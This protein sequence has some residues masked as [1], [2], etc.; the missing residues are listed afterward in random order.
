MRQYHFSLRQIPGLLFV[1]FVTLPT[2]LWAQQRSQDCTQ[3]KAPRESSNATA[4]SVRSSTKPGFLGFSHDMG[5]RFDGNG[6]I[7]SRDYPTI[8][9]IYCGLPAHKAGLQVGDIVREVNDNDGRTP[10]VLR[11]ERGGIRFN[12]T[13]DRKGE[14]MRFV[15]VAVDRPERGGRK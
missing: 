12:L 10:G 11:A 5:L 15:L 6:R 7:A 9:R 4:E 13:I 14:L 2:G 3:W 8:L 1:L